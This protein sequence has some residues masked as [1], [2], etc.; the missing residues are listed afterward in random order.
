MSEN[1]TIPVSKRFHDALAYASEMHA[2]QARKGTQIPYISHL[3]AV[4]GIIWEAGGTEDEAIAGL[5]HDGPEDQGG[6]QRL[7][8]IRRHFGDR[9]ADIVAHCS[10]T[11]ETPKPPWEARKRKYHESLRHA[12]ASTLLVSIA[13]KLHNAGQTV[14]DLREAQNAAIV[15]GKFS[16]TCEQSIWN[17]ESL[18]DAYETGATDA[19]RAPLVSRLRELVETMKHAA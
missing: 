1:R 17:Y 11:F 8:D 14:S 13:D 18:L 4:S 10:D 3:I 7:D 9:V 15:W 16:A 5:L 6:Q 19:R 2:T 12:D